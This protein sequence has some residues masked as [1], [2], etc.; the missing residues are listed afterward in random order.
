MTQDGW[1]DEMLGSKW[2]DVRMDEWL[3]YEEL[4]GGLGH[5]S[6][7]RVQCLGCV[8]LGFNSQNHTKPAW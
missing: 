3:V 1:M 2:I 6:F 4:F 7:G 8:T 5:S